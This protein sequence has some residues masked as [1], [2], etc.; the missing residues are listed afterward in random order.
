MN[1]R[2]RRVR[3]ALGTMTLLSLKGWR[4]PWWA[5]VDGELQ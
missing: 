1:R 5:H 4:L 3:R 2:A